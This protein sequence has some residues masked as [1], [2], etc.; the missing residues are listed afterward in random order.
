MLTQHLLFEADKPIALF[1][2]QL[3]NPRPPPRQFRADLP[4]WIETALLRGLA[5]A[6][7]DRFQT[8][9]EFRL[10]LERGLAGTLVRP[11][12]RTLH[13]DNQETVGPTGTPTRLRV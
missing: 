2:G 4:D 9:A 3:P 13:A 10:A 11:T 7:S 8:A 5:K 12:P 6:P 1:H